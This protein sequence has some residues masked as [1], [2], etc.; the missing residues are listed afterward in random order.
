MKNVKVIEIL[1]IDAENLKAKQFDAL[2]QHGINILSEILD[3][4]RSNKF[5]DI[6]TKLFY[7]PAGDDMGMENHCINFDWSG[8]EDTD[9]QEYLNTL[10]SLMPKKK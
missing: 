1:A 3:S 9:I 7:S 6:E 8:E 10:Q 2:K 5:L 4:L